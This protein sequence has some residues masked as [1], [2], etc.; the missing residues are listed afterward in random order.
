MVTTKHAHASDLFISQQHGLYRAIQPT[1]SSLLAAASV[2][3]HDAGFNRLFPIPQA[4]ATAQAAVRLWETAHKQLDK[5]PAEVPRSA[6]DQ[7]HDAATTPVP[8]LHADM[9]H[10]AHLPQA[11]EFFELPKINPAVWNKLFG[12]LKVRAAQLQAQLAECRCTYVLRRSSS[13]IATALMSQLHACACFCMLLHAQLWHSTAACAAASSAWLV[14]IEHARRPSSHNSTVHVLK[15]RASTGIASNQ[16]V[17]HMCS[18]A[19]RIEATG[20]AGSSR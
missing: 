5:L 15:A 4:M 16:L 6:T 11:T 9:R 10:G 19:L 1:P 2:V 3:A 7:Q 14:S 18:S 12:D 8:L 20:P 17:Q 13:C